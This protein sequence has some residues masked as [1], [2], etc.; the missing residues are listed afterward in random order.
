MSFHPI[1]SITTILNSISSMVF[2]SQ[3]CRQGL[4]SVRCQEYKNK[5]IILLSIG[6][7]VGNTSVGYDANRN[8]NLSDWKEGILPMFIAATSTMNEYYINSTFKLQPQENYLRI[9]E[10]NLDPNIESDDASEANMDKLED[11]GNKL[12]DQPVKR[13]NVDTFV[14]EETGEGTNAEALDRLA[15]ILHEEKSRRR[16]GKSA[17]KVKKGFFTRSATYWI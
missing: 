15:Q 11:V 6:T 4:G 2:L 13:M 12:L 10:C 14:P 3:V 1:I 17:Q 16:L 5:E 8:W 9:Q 7:G